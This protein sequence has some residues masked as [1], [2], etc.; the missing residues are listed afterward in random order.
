MLGKSDVVHLL[1]RFIRFA[2]VGGLC[3]GIG[4]LILWL[5]TSIAGIDYR[6]SMIFAFMVTSPIG[7][8]LNERHTF[9]YGAV[10]GQSEPLKYTLVVLGSLV[11][12]LCAVWLLVSLLE[13]NYLLANIVVTAAFLLINFTIHLLWTF[14]TR[15]RQ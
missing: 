9:R 6:I 15:F 7:F 11:A 2:G 3:Y 12:S 4:L 8:I 10:K 5:C 14:G 13:I 1:M